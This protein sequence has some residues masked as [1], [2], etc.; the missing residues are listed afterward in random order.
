MNWSPWKEYLRCSNCNFGWVPNGRSDGAKEGEATNYCNCGTHYSKMV[1]WI[2]QFADKD[3]R[4]WNWLPEEKMVL[5]S[6][7]LKYSEEEFQDKLKVELEIALTE[8]KGI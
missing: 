1:P 8:R 5:N 2:G 3:K 4:Y 7:Q 6:K